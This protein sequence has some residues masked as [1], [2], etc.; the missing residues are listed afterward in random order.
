MKITSRHLVIAFGIVV[1]IIF[2]LN[3]TDFDIE[4]EEQEQYCEMVRMYMRDKNTGWPDFNENF[5]EVCEGE[6]K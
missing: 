2:M 4:Q 1:L 6:K 3:T 5:K